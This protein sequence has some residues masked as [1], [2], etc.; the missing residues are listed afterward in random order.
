MIYN[1][2][3]ESTTLK[4]A[5]GLSVW[6][7]RNNIATLYDTGGDASII[8][9]NISHSDLDIRKLS[10]IVISHNHW[11]HK[12][13]LDIILEKT[14]NKPVVYVVEND[15]KEYSEKF[16]QAKIRGVSGPMTIDTDIWTT[17]KLPASY[18]G[19][20]LYEQSLV[21]SQKDTVVLLT[22]CSHSGIIDMIKTVKGTFP[23]KK[24]ELV[25][26]GFHLIQKSDTEIMEISN[27]L[28]D[29]Y[30]DKIAPSHC[31][32]KKAINL[33]KAEWGERF[34]DFNIGNGLTV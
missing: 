3:G 15:F 22:G 10:N 25:A 34:V 32:G 13:G 26:G 8:W 30:V 33:F 31:T 29:L 28:K 19:G 12:K 23:G 5:W 4:S 6:V 21:L 11:D 1:N 17:G 16:P 14:F 7:E 9:E 18:K 27:E 20:V 2:T 24:V